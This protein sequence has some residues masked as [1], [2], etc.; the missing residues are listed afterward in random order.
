[1]WYIVLTDNR[2]DLNIM[3]SKIVIA[4][5]KH[6]NIV[7]VTSKIM[8][9]IVKKKHTNKVRSDILMIDILLRTA[10]IDPFGNWID[11]DVNIHNITMTLN[12]T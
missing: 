12:Q 9:N 4:Q 8:V 2:V 7:M 1:M 11:P 3:S 5:Q 10:S 6:W